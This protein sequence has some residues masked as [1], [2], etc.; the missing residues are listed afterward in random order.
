MLCIIAYSSFCC[1]LF[2]LKVNVNLSQRMSSIYTA[3]VHLASLHIFKSIYT[4]VF[5][6][7]CSFLYHHH[8]LNI[9]AI[10]YFTSMI[11]ILVENVCSVLQKRAEVFKPWRDMKCSLAYSFYFLISKVLIKSVWYMLVFNNIGS[12]W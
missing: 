12:L 2:S 8:M 1:N 3:N 4:S 11:I 9:Q 6:I 7:M 10:L 5:S